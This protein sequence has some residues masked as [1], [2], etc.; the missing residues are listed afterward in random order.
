MRPGVAGPGQ[1]TAVERRE[2]ATDEGWGLCVVI[3][4]DG[5]ARPDAMLRPPSAEV[6]ADPAQLLE[7]LREAG[8]AGLG[9]AAFPTA[10]KLASAHANAATLLRLNGAECEPWICCDDALLRER[11]GA[12][13]RGAQLLLRA[14]QAESCTIAVEDDKPVAIE[15][16]VGV[17][18]ARTR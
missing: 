17:V 7:A 12:V 10:T 8:M 1:R 16:L 3:E 2:T 9:G 4:N 15:A 18:R 13:V 14:M 11:A 6:L 5:A